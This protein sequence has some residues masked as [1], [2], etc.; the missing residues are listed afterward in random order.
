MSQKR[1]LSGLVLVFI[2][3]LIEIFTSIASNWN[4]IPGFSTAAGWIGVAGIV[5][6][7]IGLSQLAKVN[8]NYAKCRIFYI[9]DICVSIAYAIILIIITAVAVS[10]GS[11]GAAVA[12]VIV[13]IIFT[14]ALFI[15]D[16]LKVKT[17][18][19]GCADVALDNNDRVY[20]AKC[21]NAWNNYLI[22]KIILTAASII[23]LCIY[24][25]PV[26]NIIF[27]V[28]TWCATAYAIIAL[29]MVLVRTI[30]TYSRFKDGNIS[31]FSASTKD[32][33]NDIKD[34][35]KDLIGDAKESMANAGDNFKEGVTGTV[36]DIKDGASGVGGTLKEG[37]GEFAGGAKDAAGKVG[38]TVADGAKT[39]ADGAKDVAGNVKDAVTGKAEDAADAAEDV[40]DEVK[41]HTD[42]A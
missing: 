16:L 17:L 23:L 32:L 8:R 25:V 24:A 14:I 7:I 27:A 29:I 3:L 19:G 26:V 31:S 30:G 41:D 20:A 28:I 39:V 12:M 13:G 21:I 42:N 1:S 18:M 33:L 6:S 37:F 15:I 22:A 36:G 11:L 35:H 4:S 34:D 5:I 10:T 40:V 9:I 2:G 38:G